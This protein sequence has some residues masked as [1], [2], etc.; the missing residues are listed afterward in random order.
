[1]YSDDNNDVMMRALT[2][3]FY[4]WRDIATYA[5][6]TE[7]GSGRFDINLD[8]FSNANIFKCPSTTLSPTLAWQWTK[9]G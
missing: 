7:T 6:Y 3:S 1:M 4:W 2:G 9:Y 8:R 5:G